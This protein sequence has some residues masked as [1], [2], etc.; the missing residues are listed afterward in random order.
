LVC[1]LK[2]RRSPPAALTER[3]DVF[4]GQGRDAAVE[5]GAVSDRTYSKRLIFRV[6]TKRNPRVSD[7]VYSYAAQRAP[8]GEN[9]CQPG[10]DKYDYFLS[11]RG[12]VAAVAR[13]AGHD[14]T[15]P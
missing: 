15:A 10:R 8:C 11:R 5:R 1:T 12:S 13:E 14:G 2:I 4:A 6:S 7:R 3:G 9:R